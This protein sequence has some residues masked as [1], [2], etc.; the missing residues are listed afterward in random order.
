MA[1]K[2]EREVSN[3]TGMSE[4]VFGIKGIAPLLMDKYAAVEGRP[5]NTPEEYKRAAKAKCYRTEEGDLGIPQEAI[6]AAIRDAA[7]SLGKRTGGRDRK[8]MIRA[9]VF[10]QP[11][12][13]SIG[14]KDPDCIDGRMVTRGKGEKVTR[15]ETFR[16]LIKEWSCEGKVSILLGTQPEFVKQCLEK[17]GLFHG[18]LSFRPEFG[19]FIV[20]KFEGVTN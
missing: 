7:Y 14:K 2:M 4:F 5:P 8:T 1:K 15:V 6:K 9:T 13:L 10:I 19:R 16:P 18:L 20:T 11:E 3:E 12:V 17:A